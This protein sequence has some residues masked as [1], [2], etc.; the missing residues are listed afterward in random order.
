MV[1]GQARVTSS[2][3]FGRRSSQTF[4]SRVWLAQLGPP[5]GQVV[6]HH[7]PSYEFHRG[8][9]HEPRHVSMPT[10][11][12]LEPDGH[13]FISGKS[14]MWLCLPAMHPLPRSTTGA[15]SHDSGSGISRTISAS[16]SRAQQAKS[17]DTISIFSPVVFTCKRLS[18][19]RR[20]LTA[21]DCHSFPLAGNLPE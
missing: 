6:M 8:F 2:R 5:A 21:M 11:V 4:S 20:F 17:S 3:S 7:R 10:L 1:L 12:S 16:P 13:M 14:S 18:D 15:R 19:K 9:L